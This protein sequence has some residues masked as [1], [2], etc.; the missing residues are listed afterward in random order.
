M[1]WRRESEKGTWCNYYNLI[2]TIKINFVTLYLISKNKKKEWANE[3]M[4]EFTNMSTNVTIMKL[5]CFWWGYHSLRAKIRRRSHR[6]IVAY[7]SLAETFCYCRTPDLEDL[8]LANEGYDSKLW[9]IPD[10]FLSVIVETNYSCL[11][12]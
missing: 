8:K 4:L 11:Y 6:E 1:E 12:P 3:I 10:S 2:I 7:F 5:N 9:L